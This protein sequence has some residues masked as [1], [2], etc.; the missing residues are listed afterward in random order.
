MAVPAAY[1]RTFV[2]LLGF[3]RPYRWSLAVSVVLAVG[4]QAAAVVIAFLTGDALGHVIEGSDR[5]RLAWLVVAVVGVG[6]ARAL[7]MA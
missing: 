6:A 7:F 4:S 3:L 1:R 2:R 5:R